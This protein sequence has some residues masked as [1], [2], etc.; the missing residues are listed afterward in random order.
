MSKYL[1]RIYHPQRDK[2]N[3]V[4]DSWEDALK[5]INKEEK[6][7]YTKVDWLNCTDHFFIGT[8]NYI[9]EIKN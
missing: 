5:K 3:T 2:D 1:V 8:D 7:I 6:D 4:V 9:R